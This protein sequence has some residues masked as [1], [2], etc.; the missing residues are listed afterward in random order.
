MLKDNCSAQYSKHTGRSNRRII[1]KFV[2]IISAIAT[3]I[4]I[5][6][7]ISHIRGPVQ[8][9][10]NKDFP[11][12]DVGD[13]VSFT[14]EQTNSDVLILSNPSVGSVAGYSANIL[15]YDTERIQVSFDIVCPEEYD[16]STILI[17]LYNPEE[18][19]DSQEQEDVKRLQKGNNTIVTVL[20]P[21]QDAPKEA[22]LRIFTGDSINVTLDNIEVYQ[23]LKKPKVTVSMIIALFITL[24]IF[25]VAEYMSLKN[26]FRRI[27]K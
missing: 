5:L 12:V 10:A 24:S 21:G 25:F 23:L 6:N 2:V 18:E 3:Y 4:S 20:N 15:L 8:Y 1:L 13:F 19:Y 14:G 26:K 7:I 17:D 11:M 9:Y 22:Q 16:Q 27:L